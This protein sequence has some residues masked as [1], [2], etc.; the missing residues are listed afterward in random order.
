MVLEL[1]TINIENFF[2]WFS[3]IVRQATFPISNIHWKATCD[4][5]V[6]RWKHSSEIY[7]YCLGNFVEAFHPLYKGNIYIYIHRCITT[8]HAVGM[9]KFESM[10]PCQSFLIK[11]MQWNDDSMKISFS[12][13]ED[14]ASRF[15]WCESIRMSTCICEIRHCIICQI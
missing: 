10:L 13:I 9:N 14:I 3:E 2:I 1:W 15:W 4:I 6:K 12:I 11:N 8:K 7:F 5:N